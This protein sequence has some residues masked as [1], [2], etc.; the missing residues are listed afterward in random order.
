MFPEIAQREG[1]RSLLCVPMIMQ[2]RVIGVLNCYTAQEH[3]FSDEETRVLST[4]ANQAAVAVEH[5]RALEQAV[6][7]QKSLDERKLIEKAKGILIE[8]LRCSEA[9]AFRIL[10]KQSMEKRK[11]MCEIAEAVL[12][13]RELAPP[14]AGVCF[15][16]TAA[17]RF[18]NYEPAG[19]RVK[20]RC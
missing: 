13:A 20:E 14:P 15:Q 11:T 9:E 10:Q 2:E 6:A 3:R 18:A 1:L 17:S 7:L 8:E 19:G 16:R 4:I 5:T 12:L